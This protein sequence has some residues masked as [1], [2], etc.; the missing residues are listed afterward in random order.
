MTLDG[1]APPRAYSV[2]KSHGKLALVIPTLREAT[3]ILGLLSRVRAAL[4]AAQ[5]GYEVLVVDDDSGD[6]IADAIRPLAQADPR[7]RLL[8]RHG[9]RGLAGAILHGWQQTDAGVLG[10]I[11]S[12]LQ[13]PPEMLPALVRAILDG[14]DLAIGSR[15]AE[16][17]GLRGWHPA[18][19]LA[20]GC[21]IWATWP[22]QH[23]CLRVCDPMSGFFLVRRACVE[24]IAFQKSGF[25]LLLE[26]LVR[27]RIRSV[28]EI[29]FT[30]GRRRAGKSKAGIRT[31]LDYAALLVRLY[32]ERLGLPGFPPRPRSNEFG[33]TVLTPDP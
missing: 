25:K 3:N 1:L 7:I 24:G 21:A 12:D 5:I 4:D 10:V 15:Y 17:G 27:G 29:P 33:S 14:H 8:V 22:L 9:E 26:I 13:H 28:A 32:R 18:R 16:G 20:S 19:R 30:F 6:G 11:D 2:E 31:A 23:R